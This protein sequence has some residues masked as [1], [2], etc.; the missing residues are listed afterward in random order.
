MK[1]V[2][3]VLLMFLSIGFG[4]CVN[5]KTTGPHIE[6]S[7]IFISNQDT[8]LYPILGE[9]FVFDPSD[10]ISQTNPAYPLTYQWRYG[11]ITI[12][13][14]G[15]Y[16]VHPQDSLKMLSNEKI[17]RFT[18]NS[19]EPYFVRLR[20]S[21]EFGSSYRYFIVKPS[22]KFD[23]GIVMLSRDEAGDA[24]FS[25][26]NTLTDEE[27]LV[28]KETSDFWYR[29]SD[30]EPVLK[31]DIVDFA[32]ITGGG[33]WYI[34]RQ[35]YPYLLSR[36]NRQ[37]YYM[38][39][40][41]LKAITNFDFSGTP[42]KLV[43]C[44]RRWFDLFAYCDDGD[45]CV[46]TWT[47][48][49]EVERGFYKDVERWDRFQRVKIRSGAEKHWTFKYILF[50]HDDTNSKLYGLAGDALEP[51]E[52]DPRAYPGE[53]VI[54]AIPCETSVIGVYELYIVT[55][56]IERP[57]RI[58]VKKIPD[59][60]FSNLQVLSLNLYN[61]NFS[62]TYDLPEGE[63]LTLK[64]ESHVLNVYQHRSILYNT[65][66]KV[67]MWKPGASIE[68]KLPLENSSLC[69]D[70]QSVNPNAEITCIAQDVMNKYIFV[71][72]YDPTAQDERKGSVYVLDS[73]DL[74]LL[75][76]WENVAYK[77]MEIYYKVHLLRD[78]F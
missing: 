44:G 53:K 63:E 5:D 19:Q 15:D 38:D 72:V 69:F 76:R 16:I 39:H 59:V 70:V 43:P 2:I 41:T 8:I 62:Y 30:E 74:K 57:S 47:W 73:F 20:V 33:D 40:A 24:M 36:T 31:N 46:Q 37:A 34:G 42:L 61:E 3:F 28:R 14:K 60:M 1:R 49:L 78:K 17:L 27:E 13:N 75:K 45:V 4:S 9:E 25:V 54:Y 71:G 26:L 65:A 11:K 52:I 51:Y 68:P 6:I 21:N 58:T 66:R 64:S 10:R 56:N 48:N 35:G 12:S 23:E 55:Q 50:L 67:Y 7:D 29:T 77:P 32:F 18:F 22:C